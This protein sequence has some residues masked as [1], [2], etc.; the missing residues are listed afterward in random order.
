MQLEYVATNK[1]P[2]SS[3]DETKRYLELCWY[4]FNNNATPPEATPITEGILKSLVAGRSSIEE[5]TENRK[6]LENLD[7]VHYGS[8][9]FAS[10]IVY[11]KSQGNFK[12]R[13]FADRKL[14]ERGFDSTYEPMRYHLT[15]GPMGLGLHVTREIEDNVSIPKEEFSFEDLEKHQIDVLNH[16][17]KSYSEEAKRELIPPKDY[18]DWLYGDAPMS[19]EIEEYIFEKEQQEGYEGGLKVISAVADNLGKNSFKEKL[20]SQS[21]LFVDMRKDFEKRFPAKSEVFENTALGVLPWFHR[22]HMVGSFGTLL[23]DK[24]YIP[25]FKQGGFEDG[26]SNFMEAEVLVPPQSN[27]CRRILSLFPYGH[28]YITEFNQLQEEF[29]DDTEVVQAMFG[30]E[31]GEIV[32]EDEVKPI[33]F[34]PLRLLVDASETDRIRREEEEQAEARHE[35]LERLLTDIGLGEQTKKMLKLYRDKA[36]ELIPQYQSKHDFEA[37]SGIQKTVKDL[38]EKIAKIGKQQQGQLNFWMQKQ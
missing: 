23:D 4:F 29:C 8:L 16:Q 27:Y 19:E 30:H 2:V 1:I 26:R 13:L 20:K 24:D 17:L 22:N 21:K 15:S 5:I 36:E 28:P 25:S 37:V 34:S 12:L 35:K 3:Q 9:G 32:L 18:D 31:L 10:Q 6:P 33:P 7:V 14:R 38:D 11:D